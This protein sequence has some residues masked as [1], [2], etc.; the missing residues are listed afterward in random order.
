LPQVRIG[1]PGGPAPPPIVIVAPEGDL[2]ARAV[3]YHL[4]ELGSDVAIVD[5]GLLYE[6]S[7]GLSHRLA[8]KGSDCDSAVIARADGRETIDLSR[9]GTIWYRRP[10]LPRPPVLVVDGDCAFAAAEWNA[11]IDGLWATCPAR[12]VSDPAC[13][14]SASKSRQLRV[15]A[16][17]G[18]AIPD[19]LITSSAA[20]A[21]AFVAQHGGR[22]IHKALTAP[23]DRFLATKR[24][25]DADAA[26]L[27]DLPLAP[28]IFQE[29][30]RGSIDLRI[31]MI[32]ERFFAADFPTST[33]ESPEAQ[34]IDNRLIL[35]FQYRKHALPADVEAGLRTLTQGLG[36]SFGT[37]DMKIDA[38]GEYVFLEI[39]P[40]GQFLYVEILTGLPLARTMAEFLMDG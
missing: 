30:V 25:S 29:E 3:A 34:W 10:R 16:D 2:H 39:N 18:L 37:I 17:V 23:S 13:Q 22:V 15:A 11:A 31:T 38:S 40:Q 5:L 20:D 12:F 9:A 27:D 26:A 33:L 8:R 36:L 28:T 4:R 7:R 24:W 32:G 35:D 6:P 14:R 19:T 21:R 1:A